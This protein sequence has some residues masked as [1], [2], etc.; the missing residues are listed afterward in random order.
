MKESG[1]Y[2]PNKTKHLK[3]RHFCQSLTK[4]SDGEDDHIIFLSKLGK[5]KAG[6]LVLL[7]SRHKLVHVVTLVINLPANSKGRK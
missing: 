5:V 1:C 6:I 4:M 2:Q 3:T 7:G